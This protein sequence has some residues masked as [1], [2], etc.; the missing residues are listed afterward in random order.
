[1]NKDFRILIFEVAENK[2]T[3]PTT[4]GTKILV[5]ASRSL[6]NIHIF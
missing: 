1:M 6:F 2:K 5:V 3:C 4:G